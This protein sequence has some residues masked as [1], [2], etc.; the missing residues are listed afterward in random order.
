MSVDT[1]FQ[2]FVLTLIKITPFND[3]QHLKMKPRIEHEIE[4][5]T[6]NRFNNNATEV[7]FFS[8][9]LSPDVLS[10]NSLEVIQV[11]QHGNL[12]SIMNS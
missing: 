2:Y 11:T 12:C 3:T 4:V 5:Q 7:Y 1:Q 9:T 8:V 6:K 10:F